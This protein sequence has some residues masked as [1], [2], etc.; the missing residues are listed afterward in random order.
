MPMMSS[1]LRCPADDDDADADADGDCD[2]DDEKEY[3]EEDTCCSAREASWFRI[4][5]A[6]RAALSL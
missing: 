1:P 2:D 4:L 5:I 3:E 6:S